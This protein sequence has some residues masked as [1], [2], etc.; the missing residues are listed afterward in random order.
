MKVYL[1]IFI[2]SVNCQIKFVITTLRF[3][4][5]FIVVK[6]YALSDICI[7]FYDLNTFVSRSLQDPSV[8]QHGIQIR[9]YMK[10][11]HIYLQP[12]WSLA[13]CSF[14]S[15]VSTFKRHFIC[16]RWPWPTRSGMEGDKSRPLFLLSVL[17]KIH[18]SLLTLFSQL[19][20]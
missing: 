13:H 12:L 5:L 6:F 2:K 17:N 18:L 3:C 11:Y 10:Q 14:S 19:T 4:I 16:P 15:A 20:N 9:R 7:Y 8:H 1:L